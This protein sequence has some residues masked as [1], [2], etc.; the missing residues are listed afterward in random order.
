MVSVASQALRLF[1]CAALG[2]R[3]TQGDDELVNQGFLL[4]EYITIGVKF[5]AA[6][7]ILH[8]KHELEILNHLRVNQTASHTYLALLTQE[9]LDLSQV[10][11]LECTDWLPGDF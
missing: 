6:N 11:A 7:L 10:F 9:I 1:I 3:L 4:P 2:A 5:L 8:L